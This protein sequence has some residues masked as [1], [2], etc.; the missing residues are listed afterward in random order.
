MSKP[1]NQDDRTEILRVEAEQEVEKEKEEL[2]AN[3][4]RKPV[5]RTAVD[6]DQDTP[7]MSE[8]TLKFHGK[9]SQDTNE[10][11]Q[12]TPKPMEIPST[13]VSEQKLPLS[14]EMSRS[15]L[16]ETDLQKHRERLQKAKVAAE[17]LEAGWSVRDTAQELK[18]PKGFI[19]K[20]SRKLKTESA[21]G[22][23]DARKEYLAKPYEYGLKKLQ[24]EE[25]ESLLESG[26]LEKTQRKIWKLKIE[27]DMMRKAGLIGGDGDNGSRI[28]LNEILLAKVV[29]S[30]GNTSAQ[31]LASFAAALKSLFSPSQPTDPIETFAKLQNITNQGVAQYKEVQAQ[32]FQQAKEQANKGLI[33]EALE[34]VS[35]LIKNITTKPPV[36]VP[37]VPPP[38]TVNPESLEL[39]QGE[40]IGAISTEEAEQLSKVGLN[41]NM[42]YTNFSVKKTKPEV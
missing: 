18:L 29:S 40:I 2:K 31:E 16:S 15:T 20:I 26:W 42:G 7:E 6:N 27:Q 24:E 19:E 21:G 10:D 9:N 30:G 37:Q 1:E 8:D 14:R 3:K 17:M 12:N 39:P 32:A 38:M 36:P 35:P 11:V 33:H 4:R 34:T 28:N 41:D 5:K 13:T 23:S 25:G 22:A